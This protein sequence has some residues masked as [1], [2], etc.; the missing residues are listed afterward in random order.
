MM[1][2][3]N[4]G[5]MDAPKPKADSVTAPLKIRFASA[6]SV[7]EL[8]LE[9]LGGA[10]KIQTTLAEKIADLVEVITLIGSFYTYRGRCK[11]CGWQTFQFDQTQA[12]DLVKTHAFTH[13][14]VLVEQALGQ[15][16]QAAAS[17][18]SSHP[19]AAR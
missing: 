3:D 2:S 18:E 10:E 4:P 13:W 5:R 6:P 19:A 12:E 15:A 1:I 17:A 16:Q 11:E 9:W 14:R 8:Q 7:A